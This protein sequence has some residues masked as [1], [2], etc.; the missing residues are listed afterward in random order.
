MAVPHAMEALLNPLPPTDEE[1]LLELQQHKPVDPLSER[2]I[3]AFW[4]KGLAHVKPWCQRNIISWVRRHN[5]QPGPKW[6][7]RVLDMVPGSPNHY[8]HFIANTT[9]F[10]PDAF[11]KQATTGTHRAP[12][13]ADLIRLPLLHLYGGAWIDVGFTL[14]RTV[15][16]LCWNKLAEEASQPALQ[17]ELAGFKM[18]VADKLDMMWNGFIAARK[19]SRIVKYWHDTFLKLWEGKDSTQGMN[20]HPLL[21][22]LPRYEVPPPPDEA[23]AFSYA[24]FVDYLI[25]MYCL[26]RVRNNV[27]DLL[28][29][30]GPQY[31]NQHVYLLD[32]VSEVYWAQAL[33]GWDGRKQF[34]L[35]SRQRQRADVTVNA[36]ANANAEISTS[37]SPPHENNEAW[38]EAEAFVQGILDTS[39]TMKLGHGLTTEVTQREYLAGIWD[40]PEHADADRERGTF[41]ARLRWASEEFVQQKEL[42]RVYLTMRED[43]RLGGR[44]LSVVG[45]AHP[46]VFPERAT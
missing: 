38:Q 25:H 29:W 41:A 23:P 22:H 42:E 2:N 7:V 15:D 1:I 33:T 5:R 45:R 12:H 46:D 28:D 11:L 9:A 18:P 44:L 20:A 36:S 43:A 19:G 10:F 39:S 24:D 21:Q 3:W 30:S 34:E 6:T 16:D 32:V 40:K 37:T 27:D 26:E 4:D 13:A 35:L 31:F 8:S 17:L 14:F